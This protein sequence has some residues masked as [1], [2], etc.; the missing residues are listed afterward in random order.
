M[1]MGRSEENMLELL[2]K[3]LEVHGYC[4]YSFPSPL[5]ASIPHRVTPGSDSS[6]AITR[7][8]HPYLFPSHIQIILRTQFQRPSA[9]LDSILI[10][11]L[12]PPP[13][14]RNVPFRRT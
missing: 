5:A 8:R 2:R 9:P 3:A 10:P 11:K 4:Q 6:V 1:E 7:P 14:I 12:Q 13:L